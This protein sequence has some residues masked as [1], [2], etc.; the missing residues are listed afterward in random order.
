MKKT[1]K[2]ERSWI[3]YDWANSAYS[4]SVTT[5]LLPT[6]YNTMTKSAGISENLSLAYLGYANFIASFMVALMAPILGTIADYKDKKKKFFMF[7][8]LLG[9]GFTGLLA[10]VPMGQWKLLLGFYV[11]TAIGFSGANIFYDSF[12]VDVTTKKKMDSVSSKGFAYG[13]IGSTIPF[14]ISIAIIA[15]HGKIG[16]SEPTAYQ[17]GFIITALWWGMFTMPMIKNVKQQYYIEPEGQLIKMSFKRLYKTLR[18][19]KEHK[20]IFLFLMAYFFYIDGV[21][22]IIKMSV[23]YGAAVGIDKMQ[24]ILVLLVG[25]LVAFPCALIYGKL[26]SKYSA[27]RMIEIAILVYVFICFYAYQLNSVTE[28]WILAALVFSSQGGIQALSRSYFGKLIPKEKS[29][30]FFGFYNIFGKFAAIFGPLLLGLVAVVT[31]KAQ[32]G[33]FSIVIFFIVGGFLLR[34]L[35]NIEIE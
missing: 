7:F 19:I 17:I 23:S 22:T 6:L 20:N 24:M 27:K 13:Y 9:V 29:N 15:T 5:A 3:M 34:R 32:F 25:Q 8:F 4:I 12:L 31:G 18:E 1:S 11:F 14:V 26:A 28:Y 21:G 30:E 35:P 33:V 16:I 2:E 10:I